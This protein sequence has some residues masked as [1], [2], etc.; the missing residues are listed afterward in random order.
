MDF[1][2]GMVFAFAVSLFV[3]RRGAA[4]TVQAPKPVQEE[5]PEVIPA[6]PYCGIKVNKDYEYCIYCDYPEA[7]LSSR[8]GRP[9]FNLKTD[10]AIT[11]KVETLKP[12]EKTYTYSQCVYESPHSSDCLVG[13]WRD[14]L[15]GQILTIAMGNIGGWKYKNINNSLAAHEYSWNLS[16]IK[17]SNEGFERLGLE[18]NC[19][20]QLSGFS[21]ACN[22][23]KHTGTVTMNAN[24]LKI[25][26]STMDNVVEYTKVDPIPP[27]IVGTWTSGTTDKLMITDT[28]FIYLNGSKASYNYSIAMDNV[29]LTAISG[30]ERNHSGTFKY[31]NGDLSL[32]WGGQA[33]FTHYKRVK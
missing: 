9:V 31:E 8:S 25:K 7:F 10:E 19:R 32:K 17:Y 3:Y 15:S 21:S 28:M 14:K 24:S 23:A 12:I 30:D 13:S 2:Y 33:S 26:W 22:G 11:E 1:I 4:K 29:L 27:T 5:K 16:Y 20:I 6:C 18:D